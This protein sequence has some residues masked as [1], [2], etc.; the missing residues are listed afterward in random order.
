MAKA[1]P[2]RNP[3]S[4]FG[5]KGPG[6]PISAGATSLN[7]VGRVILLQ[8]LSLCSQRSPLLGKLSECLTW[9]LFERAKC[10]F[11]TYGSAPPAF[12]GP[13]SHPHVQ[14]ALLF[15]SDTEI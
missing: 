11:S 10:L 3:A 15:F 14:A 1:S 6:G 7:L 9:V 5:Y 2:A 12:L 13:Q 4:R 8:V